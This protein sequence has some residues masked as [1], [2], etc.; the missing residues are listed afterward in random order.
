M[1]WVEHGQVLIYG[2]RERDNEPSG[3]M[4][5]GHFITSRAAV[6]NSSIP[7]RGKR[8]FSAPQRPDRLWGTLSLL[9]NGY[10]GQSGRGMKQTTHINLVPWSRMV[11]LYLYSY[12]FMAWCLIN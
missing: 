5:A 2:F 3:S 8:F 9:S 4:K 1:A 7:D 12:F 11:Y 6:K 10:R